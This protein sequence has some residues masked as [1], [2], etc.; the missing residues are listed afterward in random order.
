VKQVDLVTAYKSAIV[1]F[2]WPCGSKKRGKNIKS[3]IYSKIVLITKIFNV[4]G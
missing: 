4:Y 2:G 1:R 3:E